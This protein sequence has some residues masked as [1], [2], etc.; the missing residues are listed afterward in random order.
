MYVHTYP[1]HIVVVHCVVCTAQFI[2][3]SVQC[4]V[5]SVQ[6][7][8]TVY[9]VHN[10]LLSYNILFKALSKLH[11]NLQSITMKKNPEEYYKQR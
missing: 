11:N 5:N 2:V 6:C 10:V 7:K 1:I 9:S 3:C 8:S 4:T